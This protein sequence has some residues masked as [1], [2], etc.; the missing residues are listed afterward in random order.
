MEQAAKLLTNS[1][2]R[3]PFRLTIAA[4]APFSLSQLHHLLPPSHICAP[5]LFFSHS[6]LACVL[7]VFVCVCVGHVI[8]T[9]SH[10]IIAFI[11]II[12]IINNNNGKRYRG[13]NC[14]TWTISS[15]TVAGSR[16][17]LFSLLRPPSLGPF[18]RVDSRHGF[19][20]LFGSHYW[21]HHWHHHYY[22]YLPAVILT[23]HHLTTL[24]ANDGHS[25]WS[26]L[27]LPASY[28]S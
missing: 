13:N 14:A 22:C 2:H 26:N 10:S 7:S 21:H 23:P 8:Y 4:F 6:T 28:A 11:I 3:S 1:F 12:A 24:S 18:T 5:V 9:R 15:T 27:H 25:L 19:S 16:Q 17:T 20:P